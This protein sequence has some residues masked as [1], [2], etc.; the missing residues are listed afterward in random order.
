MD[1]CAFNECI[2]TLSNNKSPAGPDGVANEILKMISPEIQ[3][4][5]HKLFIIAWASPWYPKRLVRLSSL[6]KTKEK[7]HS[8]N[9]EAHSLL[10]S[11]QAGSRNQ[12]DTITSSRILPWD[13]KTLNFLGKICMPSLLVKPPHSTLLTMTGCSG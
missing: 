8:E 6:T 5:I 2:K 11:T 1:K 3:E 4:S 10:S 9:A 13:L 7:R 12:K